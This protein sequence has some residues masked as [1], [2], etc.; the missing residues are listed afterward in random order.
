MEIDPGLD[1][2]PKKTAACGFLGHSAIAATVAP[3]RR[4]HPPQSHWLAWHLALSLCECSPLIPGVNMPENQSDRSLEILLLRLGI[5]RSNDLKII[6]VESRLLY[7]LH[8][9]SVHTGGRYSANVL[10]Y[11]WAWCNSIGVL[12]IRIS[13]IPIQHPGLS[14]PNWWFTTHCLLSISLGWL[15]VFEQKPGGTMVLTVLM[16]LLG[17]THQDR[18]VNRASLMML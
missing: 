4:W 15:K 7:F 11:P 13:T 6:S 14:T 5:I 10:R 1:T 2:H 18:K 16:Y 12:I 8:G 9:S 3:L 17:E